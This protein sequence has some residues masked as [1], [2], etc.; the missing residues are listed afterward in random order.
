LYALNTKSIIIEEDKGLVV[1]KVSNFSLPSVV[2]ARDQLD[3]QS[4][5]TAF[6]WVELITV[7]P[8]LT[9]G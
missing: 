9:A 2:K 6:C 4:V 3:F 8:I 1:A 5:S 7:G